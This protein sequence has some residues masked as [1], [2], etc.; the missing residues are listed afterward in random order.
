[1]ESRS[2]SDLSND[3]RNLDS[4]VE[5]YVPRMPETKDHGHPPLKYICSTVQHSLG[6]SSAITW[7]LLPQHSKATPHAC[8]GEDGEGS[9]HGVG[10][11]RSVCAPAIC[12]QSRA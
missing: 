10:V 3:T 5:I 1:M 12:L 6:G 9:L 11:L 2:K 7:H 4:K 8:N